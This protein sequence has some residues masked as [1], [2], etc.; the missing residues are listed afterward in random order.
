MEKLHEL[1]GPTLSL[2]VLGM[3]ALVLI[4]LILKAV[5]QGG[6]EKKQ[7]ESKVQNAPERVEAVSAPDNSSE[8]QTVKTAANSTANV[9]EPIKKPTVVIQSSAKPVQLAGIPEDSILRRHYLT[10]QALKKAALSNPIPTDSILRRHY[11]AM[12]KSIVVDIYRPK[13]TNSIEQAV[14]REALAAVQHSGKPSQISAP[15]NTPD[16]PVL[17]EDSV[18]RRHF[19]SQLQAEVKRG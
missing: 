2:I 12:Q 4:W 14:N 6:A 5:K 10:E 19:L 13:K 3:M 7:L 18:L 8:V 1:M 11:D 16:I 17:P 15:V 9:V